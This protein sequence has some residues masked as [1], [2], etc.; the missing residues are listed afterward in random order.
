MC[1][2]GV[3][4]LSTSN[5][6]IVTSS[7]NLFFRFLAVV[8]ALCFFFA[9]LALARPNTKKRVAVNVPGL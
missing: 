3:S 2:G 1:A 6:I 7:P 8:F 4:F 9:F 5:V